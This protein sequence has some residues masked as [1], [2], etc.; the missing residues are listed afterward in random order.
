MQSS[1]EKSSS[2]CFFTDLRSAS[3]ISS[4]EG[5]ESTLIVL[6][7]DLLLNLS[8]ILWDFDEDYVYVKPSY[9]FEVISIIWKVS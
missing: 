2:V 5:F 7:G 6:Q 1:S 3:E 8:E 4:F 9:K